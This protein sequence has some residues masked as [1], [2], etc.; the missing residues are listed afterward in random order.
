MKEIN[1]NYMDQKIFLLQETNVFQD[2]EDL[3]TF[4]KK[5]R[6]KVEK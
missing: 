1:K 3:L 2:K 5:N 4:V 6:N